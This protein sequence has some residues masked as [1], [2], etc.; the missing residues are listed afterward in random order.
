MDCTRDVN[1]FNRRAKL[2][3]PLYSE[4]KRKKA[5]REFGVRQATKL[6]SAIQ[7]KQ[8]LGDVVDGVRL[9]RTRFPMLNLRLPHERDVVEVKSDVQAKVRDEAE[10]L[11]VGRHS[12]ARALDQGYRECPKAVSHHLRRRAPTEQRSHA[13]SKLEERFNSSRPTRLLHARCHSAVVIENKT[14][15]PRGSHIQQVWGGEIQAKI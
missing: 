15:K 8:S 11:S 2:G 12:L 6:S 14:A 5:G 1:S 7:A 10:A 13:Y 4:P 9:R 3:S